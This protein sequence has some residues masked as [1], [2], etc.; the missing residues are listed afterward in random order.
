MFVLRPRFVACLVLVSLVTFCMPTDIWAAEIQ[1]IAFTTDEI[2]TLSQATDAAAQNIVAGAMGESDA[3]V[4]A[5][6]AVGIICVVLLLA[7]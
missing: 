4:S 1:K 6:A 3:L 7:Q 2:H 5:F